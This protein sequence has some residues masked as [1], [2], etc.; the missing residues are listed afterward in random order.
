M[1]RDRDG[2]KEP[3][4]AARLSKRRPTRLHQSHPS[5]TT[6]VPGSHS[7]RYTGIGTSRRHPD[8]RPEIDIRLGFFFSLLVVILVLHIYSK[9]YLSIISI[10]RSTL[11]SSWSLHPP[12]PLLSLSLPQY[13]SPQPRRHG[14]ALHPP[15]AAPAQ[16]DEDVY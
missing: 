8:E 16:A 13:Q 5:P 14:V 10:I 2:R 12:E 3:S 7:C 1:P 11:P 6:A 15:P 9:S 4:H